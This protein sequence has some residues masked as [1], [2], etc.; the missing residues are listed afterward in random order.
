[1]QIH[2]HPGVEV[3][4]RRLFMTETDVAEA[5]R[6]GDLASPQ[7]VENSLL[8]DMRIS[9]T[10][11]SYRPKLNEWV[12]RR[13]DI[14]LT[15]EFLKRCNG[16]PVIDQHPE[17]AVLDSDSFTKQIVGTMRLPY[18]RDQEVWGIASIINADMIKRLE[19][20]DITDTSPSVVFRDTKSNYEVELGDG[21]TMLIEGRPSFVD[22]LA[23]CNQGVWSKG[24]EPSGIRIDD[25]RVVA[26]ADSLDALSRKLAIIHVIKSAERVAER[27]SAFAMKK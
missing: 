23:I 24:G 5:I 7:R 26:M 13:P 9:G 17:K 12:Y 18:I 22:H 2:I 16:L 11:V 3:A 27:L 20:A 21:E 6:D 19:A 15:D 1:M 4:L 10:G 25:S 14:Y 8:V